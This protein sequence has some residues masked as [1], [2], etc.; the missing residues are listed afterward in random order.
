M[1]DWA[2]DAV[3]ILFTLVSGES[4]ITGC[5]VVK[6]HWNTV[7]PLQAAVWPE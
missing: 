1:L 7:E 3:Q 6:F 5:V 2:P 4:Q